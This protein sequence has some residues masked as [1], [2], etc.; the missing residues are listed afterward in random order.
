MAG[1]DLDEFLRKLPGRYQQPSRA[2]VINSEGL[3]LTLEY[4]TGRAGGHPVDEVRVDLGIDSGQCYPTDVMQN[5]GG[6][7]E[8]AVDRVPPRNPLRDHCGGD[9]VTPTGLLGRSE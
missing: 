9:A 4:I 5:A 6:V 2:A 7:G 3:A 1:C 8:I